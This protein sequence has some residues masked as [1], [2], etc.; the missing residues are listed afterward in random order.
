MSVPDPIKQRQKQKTICM[1]PETGQKIAF[2]IAFTIVS[3]AVVGYF[4]GLQSPMNP[5]NPADPGSGVAKMENRTEPRSPISDHSETEKRKREP[6]NNT[7]PATSYAD[8]QFVTKE[9]AQKFRTSLADLKCSV[10]P[11]AEVKI[12]PGEKE[13]ALQ[14]RERN[15][16][17]NG[18]PPTI[19]HPVNEIGMQSCIACHGVG[20]KTETLRI[21]KM[22][23][24][25]LTDCTQC[26]VES[27][28]QHMTAALFRENSFI[29]L[30][31]PTE[32]PRA[33]ENAPP[34]IPHST[35]M[36]VDCASCHGVTG[37]QGIRSTHPWRQNCQQCHAPSSQLNQIRLGSEPEFLPAI[38]MD[39]QS[40]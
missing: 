24:Q 20:S 22:S 33:Y 14:M 16:A 31:A 15:R 3:I 32:G 37:L 29:G 40:N 10:D 38:K 6:G 2:L 11:L 39:N 5:A 21:S 9:R 1:S 4:V 23:H 17:F 12:N 13:F 35:W 34:M 36:R 7:I 19:P 30:P 27:N 28:P 25:Y 26:H 8:M 18:A